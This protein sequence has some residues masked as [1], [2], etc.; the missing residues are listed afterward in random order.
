[1]VAQGGPDPTVPAGSSDPSFPP[2]SDPPNPASLR[3][4]SV[5]RLVGDSYGLVSAFAAA[6]ITARLLGPSG[7]GF[8][9]SVI[10]LS[11]ILIYC[12]GAGLGES[13]I[14]LIGQRKAGLRE[15]APMTMAAGLALSAGGAVAMYVVS[16]VALQAKTEN[17]TLAIAFAC[18][19]VL[20]QV[21]SQIMVAFLNSLERIVAVAVIFSVY[22]TIVTVALWALTSLTNLGAAG[23]V[24]G[25]VVGSSFTLVAILVMLRRVGVPL[26]PRWDPG[27][28]RQALRFGIAVQVSNV[29]VLVTGRLDLL[30]VY[31]IRGSAAAGTYSIALTIGMLVGTIPLA[32]AQASFPRLANLDEGPARVLTAQVF[33]IGM[34]LV[35]AAAAV[36]TTLTPVAV[37]LLF[38]SAYSA[39]IG[40][41][42]VLVAG[43]VLWSGQWLLSRASAA[44]GTPAALCTSF[45]I[46]FAVMVALDLILIRP[47][48]E[49]GAAVA[50][51]VSAIVGFAVA[52]QFY[53]HGD[54]N[55]REFV[56]GRSDVATLLNVGSD[57]MHSTLRRRRAP[58]ETPSDG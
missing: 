39:A 48:G 5:A 47:Y 32:L 24:L 15:A 38:G 19:L 1:M 14:V 44:R 54:W 30:F 22:S 50:A 33:R 4:N 53:R 11:G 31:R 45:A 42:M 29:L 25:N 52:V 27:Y 12:F 40:P 58:A 20:L 13:A 57:V 28:L 43:G 21:P 35:V 8:Y 18:A 36:L 41:T 55:W 34:V 23:A 56:P 51:L 2:V 37:P 17:D 9:S 10:L 6:A 16:Q 26:R 46:S 49:M 3:R 7:K